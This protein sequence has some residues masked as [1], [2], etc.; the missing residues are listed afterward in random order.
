M[1]RE[2]AD[3]CDAVRDIIDAEDEDKEDKDPE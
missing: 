1:D 2:S 3:E